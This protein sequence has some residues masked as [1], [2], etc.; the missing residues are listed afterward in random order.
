MRT[1]QLWE[2]REGLPVHRHFHNHLGSVF[3]YRS[4]IEAWSKRRAQDQNAVPVL[5]APRQPG[6]RQ[7]I[8]MLPLLLVP[9]GKSLSSL[10]EEAARLLDPAQVEL[11]M[12][13]PDDDT[14][15]VLRWKSVSGHGVAI[16]E[17]FCLR[18]QTAVWSHAFDPGMREWP[19]TPR[20]LADQ[21][22]QC[23]WLHAASTAQPAPRNALLPK[24]G[25]REAYLKGRYFWSR[26]NEDDLRKAITCF[27]QAI[28]EDPDFP[29]PYAGLADT[30]TV[31]AF[32]E[33]VPPAEAMPRAR[34]A[35]MRAIALDP[36]L[37]EG[38]TSMGDI[39]LHFDWQ[40]E[41]A[42]REY[43]KAIAC[44][45]GYAL[46]YHWYANLLAATGQHDAAYTAV[47]QALQID[48]VSLIT[49]VWAGV[50]SHL[51]RRFDDAIRHYQNALEL[52][53]NFT[54]AH[55]YLAQAL[56]QKGR[57]K[58]ALAAFDTTIRLAGGSDCVTA[59]KAHTHAMAGD[60]GSA[61]QLLLGLRQVRSGRCAP[62]MT[63]RRPMR[64]WAIPGW[65]CAGCSAPA[66][67]AT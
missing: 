14:D 27:E 1:V 48:P 56:E 55:M 21:I 18:R 19:A 37:A 58:E 38:H 12:S 25:A 40:W 65:R 67:S 26:R 11:L 39:H 63:S 66:A 64:R 2:K 54:W 49:Q 42:G 8:V 23:L 34:D 15:Y 31:L 6:R 24:A 60:K 29:L 32:Y 33:L 44:N 61:R 7:R 53:P 47:M 4:E 17:L 5:E 9:V 52:E 50:T 28:R 62:P 46:G 30:L 10:V 41:A 3:A 35:A 45:P 22:G 43:R 57:Y 20:A 16:A 36:E 51:A 13:P 59:M